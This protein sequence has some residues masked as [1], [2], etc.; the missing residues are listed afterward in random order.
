MLKRKMFLN[1]ILIFTIIIFLVTVNSYAIVQ[2]TK[3]NLAQ[4]LQEVISS[5]YIKEKGI[6]NMTVGE[7]IIN[8]EYSSGQYE[9]KYDLS[10]EPTFFIEMQLQENM[11][12]S[13]FNVVDQH[14]ESLSVIYGAI[15]NI[16][17]VDANL[18]SQYFDLSY[19]ISIASKGGALN[20]I[21]SDDIEYG[22]KMLE[23]IKE[24]YSEPKIYDD[25]N[26]LNTYEL[27]FEARDI[28]ET[29][30][31]FVMTLKIKADADFAKINQTS[32]NQQDLSGNTQNG[33]SQ[34][35]EGLVANNQSTQ[36]NQQ[37]QQLPTTNNENIQ[38]TQIPK[39]GLDVKI[40]VA[41]AILVILL[42]FFG[43]KYRKLNDVK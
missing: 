10:S 12:E 31:K 11:N 41:I 39:T 24:V 14:L 17:N 19:F 33:N 26:N 3:D 9:I 35:Q 36:A 43:V 42:I 29:S 8:V 20:N 22:K 25:S 40:Y 16:N 7:D 37:S 18:S 34:N 21:Q 2:T 6:S 15:A 23:E 30:C 4:S 32:T 38:T 13:E 5:E 1:T 28:T 27:I